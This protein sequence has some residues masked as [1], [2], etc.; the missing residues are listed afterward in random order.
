MSTSVI[1]RSD[2]PDPN[3]ES[4][5]KVVYLIGAGATQAEA[6]YQGITINLLM[7]DRKGLGEGISTR[8]LKQIG[9]EAQTF[10]NPDCD[11]DIEKLIS[12]L[13]AS[14]LDAHFNLAEKMRR[15]YFEDICKSLVSAKVIDTPALAKGL[16][17]L[18]KDDRFR[19]EIEELSGIL[20]TNHD[21]LFQVASQQV[22]DGI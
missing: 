22:F 2:L 8:I 14:G 13:T 11:V 17:E 3:G 15:A 18:H 21:G 4:S 20:T 10:Y 19:H 6:D 7:R 16:L 9:P 12:L 5:A 1:A